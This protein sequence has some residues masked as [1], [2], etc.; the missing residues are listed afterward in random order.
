MSKHTYKVGDRIRFLTAHPSYGAFRGVDTRGKLGTVVRLWPDGDP[1]VSLEGYPGRGDQVVHPLDIEPYIEPVTLTVTKRD[2]R[3]IRFLVERV[4]I[5][6]V[7]DSKLYAQLDRALSGID[8]SFLDPSN[9]T[10][11]TI[12]ADQITGLKRLLEGTTD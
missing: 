4:P 12:S 11:Q 9:L 8:D 3:L 2:A 1:V 7:G 5:G 10:T 6:L